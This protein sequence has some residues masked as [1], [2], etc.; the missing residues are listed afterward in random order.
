MNGTRLATVHRSMKLRASAFALAALTV[1]AA[2]VVCAT[3]AT[4]ARAEERLTD[5]HFDV[6]LTTGTVTLTAKGEFHI[7]QDYPWK[8]IVGDV[9]LDKTKFVLSEKSASVTGAPKGKGVLKG[10]V[11]SK[12]QCHKVEKE[13]TI[14]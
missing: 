12:D 5:E 9:K 1:A 3:M 11:C 4:D 8:L 10:A 13:V 6:S 14:Q 2:S 7:N